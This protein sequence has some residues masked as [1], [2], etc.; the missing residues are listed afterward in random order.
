MSA[1]WCELVTDPPSVGVEAVGSSRLDTFFSFLFFKTKAQKHTPPAHTGDT[2]SSHTHCTMSGTQGYTY[3][4]V[5]LVDRS[6]GPQPLV[7]PPGLVPC[8]SFPP[9]QE[10]VREQGR[11]R[12]CRGVGSWSL[13]VAL[14]FLLLLVFGALGLGAYQIHRLQ[15]QLDGIQRVRGFAQCFGGVLLEQVCSLISICINGSL[16]LVTSVS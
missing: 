16:Y 6:G 12:G 15:T 9:A 1:K 5:F 11:A 2:H 14:L 8:W 7:Q 10:R 3:P 4:Q 13:V